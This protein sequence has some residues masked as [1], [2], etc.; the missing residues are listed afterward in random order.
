MKRWPNS[1]NARSSG[2]FSPP[3][4]HEQDL[5]GDALDAE[6][7]GGDGL[8]QL[9]VGAPGEIGQRR[10]VQ[11]GAQPLEVQH[12]HVVRFAHEPRQHL[13]DLLPGLLP[14]GIEQ[15][16]QQQRHVELAAQEP[17]LLDQAQVGAAQPDHGPEIRLHPRLAHVVAARLELREVDHPFGIAE[18]GNLAQPRRRHRQLHQLV[19]VGRLRARH[20]RHR[21]TRAAAR[22]QQPARDGQ[23]QVGVGPHIRRKLGAHLRPGPAAQRLVHPRQQCRPGPRSAGPAPAPSRWRRTTGGPRTG[24]N[25]RR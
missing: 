11:G 21:R 3:S 23:V 19:G 14:A 15:Q 22:R 13:V 24:W 4:R 10:H 20:R 17:L 1:R 7:A 18:Q 9:L 16:R 6:V 2:A 5:A 12:R 8:G 25:Q